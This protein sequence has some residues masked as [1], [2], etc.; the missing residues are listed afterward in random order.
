M[1]R[2]LVLIAGLAGIG[3]IAATAVLRP[4]RIHAAAQVLLDPNAEPP[5]DGAVFAE[6]E[7]WAAKLISAAESQI[8]VTVRYDPAYEKL[9]Y[10]LGDVPRERG[11][12]T[13][14]V[15]RAYRDGLGFDLQKAVNEDMRS[16]FGAYPKNWGLKKP[17]RN[18][19]HRRVPNLQAFF[20][21]K[22]AALTVSSNAQDFKPGDVVTQML[23]GNLPHIVVVSHRAN[24]DGTRPLIVHN[25]GAGTRSE[26]TLFSYD[27]TG[28]YRFTA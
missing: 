22:G 23:P 24:A 18:I 7:P 26:D 1:K 13:D 15:I 28:H 5:V 2:R 25:I 4:Q 9:K 17:D 19:D 16:A 3:T 10:P 20:K 6:A 11:V 27:I 8:G 12:C 21:R 14:V